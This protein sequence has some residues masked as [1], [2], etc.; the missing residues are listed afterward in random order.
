MENAAAGLIQVPL[1]ALA[2]EDGLARETDA[3]V[4]AIQAKGGHKVTAMHVATDHSRSDHRIALESVVIT[5]L[6]GLR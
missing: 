5:W 1:L 2:A 4:R 6:A 3:L